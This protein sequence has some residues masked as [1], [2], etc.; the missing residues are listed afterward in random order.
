MVSRTD[1]K[2][3]TRLRLLGAARE[4]FGRLGYEGAGVRE[5]AAAAGVS[6]GAIFC[7]WPD[8]KSQLWREVMET[9][10]DAAR[11]FEVM[12]GARHIVRVQ[13]AATLAELTQ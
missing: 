6:T 3:R 13:L 12:F 10:P 8:G 1:K 7:H 5:I 9:E 2:T 4:L 11:L